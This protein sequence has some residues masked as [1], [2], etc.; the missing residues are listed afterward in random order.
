MVNGGMPMEMD[1]KF[2]QE[3]RRE[4][5]AGF[6]RRLRARL[7]AQDEPTRAFA[8]RP[9]MAA[10]AGI[11]VVAALFA[12]P[13]VRAGAQ[14][15]LD[16]FRVR[17]F[18]AV[19]FDADRFEKLRT[20]DHDNAMLIF[21][22][23][24]VIQEP[25][26]P[27]VQPSAAAASALVG[28]TVETPSYLPKGLAADTVTVGGE[29]RVRLGVNTSRLRELLATLDL[30]D[31]EVPAGLDGQDIEVHMH[32]VVSQRF[33]SERRHLTLIQARSPEVSLP[34]GLDLARM[35]EMGLRILGLDPG[36][37]RRIAS[38]VDWRST[39]LVPVPMNASSFRSV[40][41]N[42]NPGLLVTKVRK[43]KEGRQRDA[44]SVVMWTVGDRVFALEG[45]GENSDLMQVAESVR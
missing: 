11:A 36:E 17:S 21:D 7:D 14:S 1:D 43:D 10:A 30:R 45:N 13:A 31:V 33:V 28:Y 19:P 39:L 29:G 32:P 4:P 38:T 3:H 12:F 41:V 40:T 9:L 24:Q 18:V 16:L 23:K 37:A 2:L 5:A 20:V 34:T 25:G 22:H 44:G 35:G 6:A 26:Q 15:M 27:Q 8:W 42:G